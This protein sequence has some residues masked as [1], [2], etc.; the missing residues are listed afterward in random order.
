M[1]MIIVIWAVIALIFFGLG[2]YHWK[3]ANNVI[4]KFSLTERPLKSLGTIKAL[5]LDIDQP[6]KDFAKEFNDYINDQNDFNRRQNRY[7]AA[8]YWLS[9][10]LCVLSVLINSWWFK[11]R[12]LA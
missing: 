3:Q 12:Y 4:P 7:A 10:F 11:K 6:I 9:S 2:V 8:G 1:K 5:G